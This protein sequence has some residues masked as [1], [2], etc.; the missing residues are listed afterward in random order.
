[1]SYGY[2]TEPATNAKV[3]IHTSMG[4]LEVEL[5]GKE[6]PKSTRNFIQLAQEGYYDGT[7]FHRLVPGFIIQGGD[8]TGTGDGGESIYEDNPN[9][10]FPDEF[11]QRLRFN[12]RGLLAMASTE[13][14]ENRS[15]FFFTLDRADELQKRYTL[16]GKIVGDTLFNLLKMA[17]LEV[18]VHTDRPLY[19]PKLLSIE[20]LNNPFEDIVPR[21]VTRR[22]E[23]AELERNSENKP[24]RKTKKNKALL[25]FAADEDESV[26]ESTLGK[27]IKLAP[28]HE[29]LADV[30][31]RLSKHTAAEDLGEDLIPDKTTSGRGF[32]TT[33]AQ[34]HGTPPP[35]VSKRKRKSSSDEDDD[36][37]S[38]SNHPGRNRVAELLGKTAERAAVNAEIAHLTKKLTRRSESPPSGRRPSEK[39]TK[40]VLDGPYANLTGS[41]YVRRAVK[42]SKEEK[43]RR[44]QELL[45]RMNEFSTVLEKD[46]VSR[47]TKPVVTRATETPDQMQEKPRCS[48]HN[49]A[50]C[51]SCIDSF[52]L[53]VDDAAGLLGGG[54][55]SA[56]GGKWWETEL[57]FAKDAGT[58]DLF[59]PEDYDVIDPREALASRLSSTGS[60]G[61]AVGVGV[62]AGLENAPKRDYEN[63][64]NG[65]SGRGGGRGDRYGDDR[66]GGQ[67]DRGRRGDG[68]RGSHGHGSVSSSRSTGGR[69]EWGGRSSHR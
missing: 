61:V 40:P 62:I 54:D 57:V 2:V 43:A 9:H 10:S 69:D 38:D 35:L 14:G 49:V 11:H 44:E 17:E 64:G 22:V 53:T 60:K 63:R 33:G 15:Q 34:P 55:E 25:S 47:K 21:F 36:S 68:G 16:F 6:C 20:V 41:T 28:A 29:L 45:A 66:Y 42:T 7:I 31:P 37:D 13:V 46:A 23:A 5:W 27:K 50:G 59:R 4:D 58:K 24:V 67:F 19:P 32:N 48:L 18:D 39:P 51:L 65:R 1:M 52:D 3:M 26:V 8:P 30:D 12:R 56:D